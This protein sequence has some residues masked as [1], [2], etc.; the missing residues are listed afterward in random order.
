MFSLTTLLFE[1][2]IRRYCAYIVLYTA[3]WIFVLYLI[4]PPPFVKL[5]EFIVFSLKAL[6]LK[7]KKKIL[8]F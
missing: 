3:D 4:Y 5:I 6:R 1:S 7:K 8:Y 2:E